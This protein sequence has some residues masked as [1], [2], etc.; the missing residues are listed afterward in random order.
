MTNYPWCL[1][2]G[3][4]NHIGGWVPGVQTGDMSPQ[5]PRP[6]KHKGKHLPK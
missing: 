6:E 4:H 1:Q 5:E 2:I 3:L